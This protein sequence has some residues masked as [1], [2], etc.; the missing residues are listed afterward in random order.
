MTNKLNYLGILQNGLPDGQ[1]KRFQKGSIIA[2][3]GWSQDSMAY[4]PLPEQARIA[5]ALEDLSKIHPEARETFE[6]GT[7][8]NWALDRYAGDIEPL[9]RPYDRLLMRLSRQ[10][11]K[12]L[13]A[14]QHIAG[15]RMKPFLNKGVF[16]KLLNRKID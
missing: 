4:S 3:Y 2:S 8:H 1:D 5:E 15:V 13:D 9:F 14:G 6:F 7:S 12:P 10:T 11:N 16:I